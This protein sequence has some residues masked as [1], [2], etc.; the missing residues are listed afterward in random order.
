MIVPIVDVGRFSGGSPDQQRAF[1]RE[2]GDACSKIGFLIV[3]G[4]GV[5]DA[6]VD[7]AWKITER[8]FDLGGAVKRAIP[9]T[10]DYP[11]GYLGFEEETLARSRNR[12]SAPDLK[13][14]FSIGPVAGSH[15]RRWPVAPPG[16]EEAWSAYYRAMERLAATLLRSFA[17]ALDLDE[18]WFDDKIDRHA[19]ALR[20]LNYPRLSAVSQ[21]HQLRASAHTDYGSLTILKSGG[22]GLQVQRRDGDWIDVP[23]VADAFV[24]NLG[25]L[26]AVWTN[27]R[28]V[29]TM[30]RVVVPPL[31]VQ[32]RRQS[33][34]F[35]HNVN[36]DAVIEC[37][38][39]CVSEDN[40]AKYPPT[41]AG[42]HLDR[43]H[44][45]ATG[46]GK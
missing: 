1:A 41:T 28:W 27:D 33:I 42:E 9:L 36:P 38:E 17:V 21:K 26:M 2:V 4:H 10:A 22:P 32:E 39:S 46:D 16:F 11:F 30:H 25:D 13:E 34:A 7:R 8:Y 18:R 31:P 23:E 24:V 3:T 14:S 15:G 40:P 5:A 20:A 35:F 43:K 12:D 45:A 19:S 44:R 6:V 29:S 37:I